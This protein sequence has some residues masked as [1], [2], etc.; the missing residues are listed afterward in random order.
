MNSW[1]LLG[2]MPGIQITETRQGG[3]SGK[4]SFRAF[5]GEGY[6]NGIKTLIDGVPSNVNS[7][8]QRFIDMVFPLDLEYIEMV[9]GTNDPRYGLHNIAGNVNMVTRQGGQ[10]RRQ[11]LDLWQLQYSR[12]SAGDWAGVR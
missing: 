6:I 1:E 5:N 7:G 11:P 10:L 8:N 2:Q 4:V 9:R 12:A 3:E